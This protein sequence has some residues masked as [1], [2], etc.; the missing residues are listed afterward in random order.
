MIFSLFRR[1]FLTLII[2]IALSVISYAIFMRDPVNAIFAEPYIYSGYLNYTQ[3][4]LRGDL[5]ITYN[6]GNSLRSLILTVLP[7]TLELCFA[8]MLLALLIGLPLGL[9][10]AFQRQNA[11]G[12]IISAVSSLGLSVP[13]FWIAP[14]L[15]YFA[16][17]Q[18]WEI[19]AVGQYNLLYEIEHVTGFALIDIWFN[20]EPY[21]IKI[22]QNVL[23]HLALPTMVLAIL[24]TMDITRLVKQRAEWILTQNYVKF[25]QTRGWNGLS[26]LRKY[27]LRHTLPVIIPQLPRLVTF[28]LAQAMLI[29]GTLG[30]PGIGRWLMD[31]VAHQDYNSISAGVIVIGLFIILINMLTEIIMFVI[32]PFNKKG[33]YAR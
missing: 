17:V 12:K 9:L 18:G 29:E 15:L 6:G 8:A 27:I 13:V 25:S 33:W 22:I 2:L 24:P 28:V 21:R 7:P 30:W 3:N 1:I 4:L 26:I 5:G 23:Q 31:A 14:L 20:H 16:A 32:D 19:S 10:G 11:C